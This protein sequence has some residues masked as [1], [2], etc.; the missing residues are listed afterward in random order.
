MHRRALAGLLAVGCLLL[1]SS[2]RAAGPTSTAEIEALVERLGA[3]DYDER[4]AAAAQLNALGA[5]AVDPLLAAAEVS[6]D[7]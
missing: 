6:A 7:L 2:L 4:E 1:S 5:A 3:A